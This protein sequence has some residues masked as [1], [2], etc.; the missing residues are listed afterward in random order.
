MSIAFWAIAEKDNW[1]PQ[2]LVWW[3][4]PVWQP[5]GA[6]QD[7]RQQEEEQGEVGSHGKLCRGKWQLYTACCCSLEIGW[8]D[9]GKLF[10]CG[11]ISGRDN[12]HWGADCQT[13]RKSSVRYLKTVN[14]ASIKLWRRKKSFVPILVFNFLYNFG[15]VTIWVLRFCHNLSF[16]VLSQFQFLSFVPIWAFEFCH[17]EYFFFFLCHNLFF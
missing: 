3:P 12:C 17:N 6:C 16:C 15:I 14:I 9:N 4:L 8:G 7:Q 11:S 2:E 10:R 13:E 1:Y 5:G